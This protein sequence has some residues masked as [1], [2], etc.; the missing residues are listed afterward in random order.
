MNTNDQRE[1][2][3]LWLPG[4]VRRALCLGC[5]DREPPLPQRVTLSDE[6]AL[7][8]IHAGPRH[9]AVIVFPCLSGMPETMEE[10][11]DHLDEW[12]LVGL[13]DIDNA[14][15]TTAVVEGILEAKGYTPYKALMPRRAS[16]YTLIE[17]H[18]KIEDPTAGRWRWYV[19]REYDPLEHGRRL[20]ESGRPAAA[21]ETLDLIP[22]DRLADPVYL[23]QV[24]LELQLCLLAAEGDDAP[25]DRLT[26]FYWAQELFYRCMNLYPACKEAFLCQAM[27]WRH[28]DRPDMGRRLLSSLL[29][30]RPETSLAQTL[31]SIPRIEPAPIALEPPPESPAG[32]RPRLLIIGHVNADVGADALYDGL[33]RTLGAEQVVE[34]PWKAHYHGAPTAEH[35]HHPCASN[36]PGCPYAVEE[37]VHELRAGRFDLILYADPLELTATE[38]VERLVWANPD[39]PVFLLDTQD[40]GF[41]VFDAMRRRIRRETTAGAFKR[42]MLMGHDYGP[43]VWPL[44]LAC[45]DGAIPE[46]LP[47]K[48]TRDLFWAGHR[49]LGLRRLYLDSVEQHFECP[50][51]LHVSPLEYR[52][53]LGESLLGLD[54][55]GLGFDTV[56]YYELPAHGCMLLAE[57]RPIQIPNNF[58]DGRE[59]VFFDD[60]PELIEKLHYYL[61][62]KRE[63]AEIARAG[64][65]HLQLHHTSSARARQALAYMHQ[66]LRVSG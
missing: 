50:L 59:A 49:H 13:V 46:R 19:R 30:A 22:E 15:E 28:I 27:F 53:M 24:L 66:R 20:F 34:Y 29:Y 65:T 31:A 42:E 44:N 64:H 21:F 41:N 45:M 37:L 10:A 33:C 38:D 16:R 57:R 36:H 63:A 6:G 1:T 54:F 17:Q 18:R 23:L 40:Q 52:K 2:T 8:D 39:T 43:Q 47:P 4:Y 55:F 51:P 7:A 61:A 56:R 60:L 48:R 12:G 32:F 3:A 26:R 5:C 62:H 9:D 58:R 14:H 25:A 35:I 11:L